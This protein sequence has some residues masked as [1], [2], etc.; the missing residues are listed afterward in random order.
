MLNQNCSPSVSNRIRR[1]AAFPERSGETAYFAV[2]KVR[3][4]LAFFVLTA[5]VSKSPL[6][7][8]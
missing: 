6:N 3:M 1:H 8:G 4:A 7:I 5:L 2:D